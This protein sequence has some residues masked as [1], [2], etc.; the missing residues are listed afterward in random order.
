MR[1]SKDKETECIICGQSFEEDWI[2]CYECKDWAHGEC[3]HIDSS[4]IYYYCDVC[5]AK[6]TVGLPIVTVSGATQCFLSYPNFN[7]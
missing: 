7:T 5:K 4:D 1:I 2:Q 3:V 6:K